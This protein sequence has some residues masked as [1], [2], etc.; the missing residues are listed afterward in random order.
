MNYD[1][2]L[3]QKL[4]KILK[5]KSIIRGR[6]TL[7]SGK[8]SSYYIDAKMTSLDSHGVVLAAKLFCSKLKGID[9][10]GGPTL[11]A[12]PF[13]GAILYE[14]WKKKKTMSAF[15]VRSKSKK[16]GTQKLIEGP[17]K[18]GLDVAIIEDVITTGTSVYQAIKAVEK[19]GARVVKVLTLV[20]REEGGVKF[21]EEKG[22]PVFLVFKKSHLGL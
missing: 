15:I 9:S 22:Y 8:E 6:I 2:K 10:I 12:D 21:L 13:L 16:H 3:K 5:Q 19:F 4:L 1:K 14:C 7:S 17:L 18:P 20:D 11:G